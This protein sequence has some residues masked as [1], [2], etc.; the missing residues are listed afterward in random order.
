MPLH[1]IRL[2][3]AVLLCGSLLLLAGCRERRQADEAIDSDLP[4]TAIS[5]SDEPTALIEVIEPDAAVFEVP[6]R[7]DSESLIVETEPVASVDSV[8]SPDPEPPAQI[9]RAAA[10]DNQL[11][12]LSR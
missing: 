6:E 2:Y 12:P 8:Q 7:E 9:A 4:P 11:A 3:I 1:S 10:E 5:V